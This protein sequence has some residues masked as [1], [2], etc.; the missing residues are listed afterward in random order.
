MANAKVA[1]AVAG[2]GIGQYPQTAIDAFRAAIATAQT[3]AYS[4]TAT[5]TQVNQAL[6]TLQAAE[7]TFDSA[8]ETGADSVTNLKESGTGTSW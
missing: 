3:V 2:T 1:A 7:I 6:I 8:I 4:T 5:Q